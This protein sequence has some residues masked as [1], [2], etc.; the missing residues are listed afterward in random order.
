MVLA[1][2]AA[3]DD[4]ANSESK[5]FANRYDPNGDRTL[6]VITKIDLMDKGTN[7]LNL[8]RGEEYQLKYGYVAVKG[9]SQQDIKEGK[10]IKDALIE[11]KNTLRTT[12]TTQKLLIFK[13]SNIFPI[14]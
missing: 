11:E 9:R 7:A 12:Q 13:E 2:H 6:G 10:T 5:Q 8:L 14:K 4:I 3:N 1:I